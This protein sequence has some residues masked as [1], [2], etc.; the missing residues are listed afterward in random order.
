MSGNKNKNKDQSN[1]EKIQGHISEKRNYSSDV[2][3]SKETQE[4]FQKSFTTDTEPI[5]PP[6]KKK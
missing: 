3:D 6:K 1:K 5:R 4:G 2:G